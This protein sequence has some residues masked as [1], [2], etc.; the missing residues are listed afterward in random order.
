VSDFVS[1]YREEGFIYGC[2]GHGVLTVATEEYDFL[3]YD[4]V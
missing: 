2:G 4:A 3:R 1:G